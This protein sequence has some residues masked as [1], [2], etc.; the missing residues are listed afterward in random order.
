MMRLTLRRFGFVL[1]AAFLAL[2]TAASLAMGAAGEVVHALYRA[3]QEFVEF[4]PLW[5]AGVE[6][7]GSDGRKAVKATRE[8]PLGGYLHVYVRNTGTQPLIIGDVQLEGISLAEALRLSKDEKA[9]IHPANVRIAKIPKEQIDRLVQL[10]EPVWWKADPDTVPPGGFADVTVRLRRNPP[11]EA[12]K[13]AVICGETTLP[14]RVEV[15]KTQPCLAGVSFSQD[16]G[17]VLTYVRSSD[18]KAAVPSRLFIDGQEVTRQST[19]LSDPTLDTVV[20]A[21]KLAKPVERGSHHYFQVDFADSSRAVAGLRATADEFRYGMWGY[22]NKGNLPR[23]RADYFLKDMEAHNINLLMYSLSKEVIDFMIGQEGVAYSQRTGI[24]MMASWPGNAR[25]PVYYF[26]L[27]EPD[28]H[29]YA[30]NML[31]ANVRLGSLGQ[32]LVEKAK[33][34]R[35]RDPVPPLLLNIDN[36][37]KP[38][39]WYLYAQL[40][41]VMCADPYYSAEL[42][43]TL[44]KHPEELRYFDKPAYVYGVASICRWACAP[45]PLHIILN[46]VRD[47]NKKNPFRFSTPVEKRI[48][49]YYA[50]AGGATSLSYWWYTPYDECYGVGGDDARGKALWKEMGVLGAE[51]RTAG[52]VIMRSCPAELP[53][54]A[55]PNLWVRT[56]LAG[57]DSVI[58]LVVNDTSRGNKEG[59]TIQT[60]SPAE[61]SVQV[62]AWL[63][64]VQAVEVDSGGVKVVPCRQE[65]NKA[66]LNLSSVKVTRLVILTQ[67]GNLRA[68]LA[69]QR[70][71]WKKVGG[72]AVNH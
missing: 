26:L 4:L 10:G 24:R 2:P 15:K 67:D 9:G 25:K 48:E 37:Y 30:V 5:R 19:I 55:S 46:C 64:N 11:T 49:V 65:G 47:D 38:E 17:D 29:D 57:T 35:A 1:L 33:Q 16:F 20:M 13:L 27:D 43:S 59:T 51:V 41:D 45:R 22:I 40:P 54:Q 72:G 14:L 61:V 52:P 34:I 28:A 31:E 8:V 39:N 69:K 66:V 3:D 71:S 58:V 56:L 18:R 44:R 62:P 68:Q 53:V 12:L 36:T 70:F 63:N 23:E 50:L 42:E 60:V 32:G 7:T 6:E 21:T